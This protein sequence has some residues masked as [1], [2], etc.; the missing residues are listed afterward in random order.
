MWKGFKHANSGSTDPTA[1]RVKL[2]CRP[3][4][5]VSIGIGQSR[6][7]AVPDDFNLAWHNKEYDPLSCYLGNA[8]NLCYT[9][10]NSLRTI[11]SSDPLTKGNA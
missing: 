6:D 3:A 10:A 1:K 11:K 5:E 9:K 8:L 7:L 2:L 4:R